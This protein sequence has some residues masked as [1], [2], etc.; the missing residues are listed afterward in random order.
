MLRFLRAL[1]P[2]LLL[3]LAGCGALT[4]YGAAPAATPGVTA[5]TVA[6]CYSRLGASAEA[7]EAAAAQD[8]GPKTRLKL[9]EQEWNMSACPVL[10]PI[11]ATFACEPLEPQQGR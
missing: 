2:A 1:A 9:I 10:T 6:V 7:V 11:R 8:C 3:G 5:P 4:P